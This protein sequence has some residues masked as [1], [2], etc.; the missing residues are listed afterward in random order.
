MWVSSKEFREL[1]QQV[2]ELKRSHDRL[3]TDIVE[4]RNF[5]VYEP[6]ALERRRNYST[7]FDCYSPI[8]EQRISLKDVVQHI[9]DKLGIELVYVEGTPAKV[10]M[11]KKPKA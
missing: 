7:F 10:D 3:V 4:G 1:K 11:Q 6:K 9:L 8:P 5:T 2:D